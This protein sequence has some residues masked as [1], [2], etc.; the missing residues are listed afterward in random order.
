MTT[1][2]LSELFEPGTPVVAPRAAAKYAT[3]TIGTMFLVLTIG[4]TAASASPLA[5]L[6][7]GAILMAMIYAG[8]HISGGHYNPAVTV[9]ALVRGRIDRRTAV[10]YWV[11]QCV[12][13]LLGTALVS[14]VSPVHATALHVTGHAMVAAL[15]AEALVTFALC[16]VVLN[17]ATSKAH[18]DNS[19]YGLAI[20]FTVAA[21]AIA[22]GPISGGAFN[23]A[24]VL[25]GL[26]MGT[27]SA[28]LVV[29]YII[30]QVIAGV[31]AG[32]AFRAANPDD[33]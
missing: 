6:A 24:V 5:P 2:T 25:G 26:A 8:G 33:K 3:E 1:T 22:V 19:F 10:G 17:V 31:T 32:I 30:V 4:A 21:G 20:G 15:V 7:I 16:Y 13:A 18:P 29:P 28:S 23:P 11:S 14:V 12:G 9:A 27:L